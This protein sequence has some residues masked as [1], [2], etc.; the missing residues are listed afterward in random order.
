M[1]I[2]RMG[3]PT[4]LI[5]KLQAA[6]NLRYFVETGTYLGQTAYWASQFFEQVVTIEFSQS[7]Y[8]QAIAQYA[9][10]PNLACRYGHTRDQLEQLVPQLEAPALFWL[11]AHW[12]GG[13]TYGETDECPLLDEIETINQ[14]KFEHFIL[15]DDARL[16]TAPP[17][18]P[19]QIQQWPNI[20]A[21]LQALNAATGDR[22]IVIIG[23]AIVAVPIAA[24]VLVAD[25]CQQAALNPQTSES[26]AV[27]LRSPQ[28]HLVEVTGEAEVIKNLPLVSPVIFDIGA[29][30]GSWTATVLNTHP[31][32]QIHAFEPV[33]QTY[34]TL[35]QNLAAPIQ[36]GRV[37]PVNAAI[38]HRQEIR[39]FHAYE[40][41]SAWSTFHRRIEVEQ[42]VNL[43]P[44]TPLSVF[45]TTLD[46]YCQQMAIHHIG[47]IKIDVEGG[48]LE[49]LFGAKELLKRGRIDYL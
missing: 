8:E 44:P 31:N 25:Y 43:A 46:Q 30:V 45:T 47:F 13:E 2:V 15:I 16:F 26:A 1:G 4:E 14:S 21:I 39:T 9:H 41:A 36:A 3:P 6:H 12:S 48:E 22:Y 27:P 5:V 33:P 20:T 40:S 35:L 24:R 29:N 19:H 34:Y 17:P 37:F 11:D 28:P 23:D 10:V 49:A 38:A 7:L 42:Q 32:A 18:P